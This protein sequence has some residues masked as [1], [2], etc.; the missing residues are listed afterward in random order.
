MNSACSKTNEKLLNQ[1]NK[2]VDQSNNQTR[3]SQEELIK[4]LQIAYVDS[5]Q[6]IVER[7]Y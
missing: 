6:R 7:Y 5:T 3:N 2:Q 4:I 1:F